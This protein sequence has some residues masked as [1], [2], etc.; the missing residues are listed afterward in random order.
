MSEETQPEES[1]PSSGGGPGF[2]SGL[3]LGGLLGATVAM[4]LA[5]Q[6]G[7]DT[8]DLLK[9]KAREVSGRARDAAEDVTSGVSTS[10]GD[11]LTRGKQIVE[12]AKARFDGAVAEGKDAA[13]DARKT[14]DAEK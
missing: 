3:F 1:A 7:E 9:A 11:L 6:A 14:L 10:A 2:L 8:R 5:P 13:D 4:V 12:D